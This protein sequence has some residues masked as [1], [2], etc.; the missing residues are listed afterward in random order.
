MP[1]CVKIP[2]TIAL[3]AVPAFQ[4]LNKETG[5]KITC[6]YPTKIADTEFDDLLDSIVK[7]RVPTVIVV[8]EKDLFD[9]F[10]FF[11]RDHFGPKEIIISSTSTAPTDD[12]FVECLD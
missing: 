9:A 3:W 12:L 8:V 11:L 10:V 5:V 7:N 6:F 1:Q 2:L 4:K